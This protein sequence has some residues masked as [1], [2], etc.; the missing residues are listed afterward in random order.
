MSASIFSSTKLVVAGKSG[1]VKQ[2]DVRSS[3]ALPEFE[4][5]DCPIRYAEFS[6]NTS[7]LTSVASLTNGNQSLEAVR[8]LDSESGKTRCVIGG[9]DE[10]IISARFG[11][12]GQVVTTSWD[13]TARIWNHFTGQ[14]LETL[15]GHD[16]GVTC[17]DSGVDGNWIVT[18]SHDQTVR[19]WNLTA[20]RR[21]VSSKPVNDY[22]A[23][24]YHL[25]G[26]LI[27]EQ[28][29]QTDMRIFAVGT[30]KEISRLSGGVPYISDR[31][32]FSPD[33]RL[34]LAGGGEVW[35]VATGRHLYALQGH[36]GPIQC[37]RFNVDS[38]LIVTTGLDGT[39]RVWD[40]ATGACGLVI[41]VLDEERI[42]SAAFDPDSR[43]LV[44]THSKGMAQL[45]DADSGKE[46]L[47]IDLEGFE[48]SDA[49]FSP[50]GQ[51]LATA[52]GKRDDSGGT[53]RIDIWSTMDG[54]HQL[55]MLGHELEP[56]QVVFSSQ[57]NYVVSVGWERI[58]RIW[59]A[60][61][62][63][64]LGRLP[65][66][67]DP[68]VPM[69]AVEHADQKGLD[70]AVHAASRI[71]RY[72]WP[73]ILDRSSLVA[74]ARRRLPR[75]LLRNQRDQH[76]LDPEP[77]RWCVELKKWPYHT[78]EWQRWLDDTKTGRAAPLPVASSRW[79]R[80]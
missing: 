71:E 57:G 14:H 23:V 5:Q 11:A 17:A 34:I 35:D 8:I 7:L 3:D 25:P 79:L 1:H 26:K 28:I 48:V 24:T 22:Y 36:E 42:T 4:I 41:P 45:W 30:R 73:I 60:H 49:A 18:G 19:I 50:D 12:I 20:A 39:V 27:A 51:R 16:E 9:H 75:A 6:G 69:I 77:P 64:E 72:V 2:F 13:S 38:R 65:A 80:V 62:G 68:M 78:E 10:A 54:E 70:L 58:I 66:L 63:Q 37:V 55:S 76:F 74:A 15:R 33:S 31:T 32:R 47:A 44:S 46:L 40:A 53:F 59:S 43:R 52:S 21:R 67:D 61:S 29:H 56:V